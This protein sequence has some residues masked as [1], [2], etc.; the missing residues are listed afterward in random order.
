M[1]VRW[2]VSMRWPMRANAR[3]SPRSAPRVAMPP[4]ARL[5]SSTATAGVPVFQWEA[6]RAWASSA[7]RPPRRS[8]S[9]PQPLPARTPP[10]PTTTSTAGCW[11]TIPAGT[12]TRTRTMP[13]TPT[14]ST[15]ACSRPSPITVSPS[16]RSAS[17]PICGVCSRPGRTSTRRSM[18]GRWWRRR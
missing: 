2:R 18:A 6:P 14:T 7:A 15:V 8:R 16:A 3:S 1:S 17:S 13:R 9:I 11:R 4:S 10:R 5:R 12:S